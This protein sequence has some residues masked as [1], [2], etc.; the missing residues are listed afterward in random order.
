MGHR[1]HTLRRRLTCPCAQARSPRPERVVT[2][3]CDAGYDR[4][5]LRVQRCGAAARGLPGR[6]PAADPAPAE[7]ITRRRGCRDVSE[8]GTPSPIDSRQPEVRRNPWRCIEG[9]SCEAG[10]SRRAALRLS[11]RGARVAGGRCRPAP[12]GDA[13][14]DRRRRDLVVDSSLP[15]ATLRRPRKSGVAFQGRSWVMVVDLAA[16]D[17]CGKCSAGVRQEPLHSR[18][19]RVPPDLQDAGRAGNRAVL[20]SASLLPLRQPA[21]CARSVR[22]ARRS[23]GDDGIVLIDNERC[24]GCRFCMAACPFSV[25][26]VQ[27]EP[28]RQPAG[29]GGSR[30]LARVGLPATRRHRREVRLLRRHGERRDSYRTASARVRWSAIYFG[31]ENEDAVTNSKG[32]TCGSRNCS[33]TGP[34]SATW[35]SSARSR[36]CYYLPPTTGAIRRRA[37][38]ARNPAFRREERRSDER[39]A[40][41]HPD[42]TRGGDA[43][44]PDASSVER[45][46]L[47]TLEPLGSAGRLWIAAL[48]AVCAAA[49]IAWIY[50]LVTASASP[51]CVTTCRGAPT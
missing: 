38:P 28:A 27:L 5:I 39:H 44:R 47:A 19:S 45:D 36:A 24:I 50:Q 26:L 32:D 33:A 37:S 29:S 14:I 35:R 8:V 30:L 49:L 11:E 41:G 48:L 21:L 3:C 10:S 15:R 16:C 43:K 25:A 6:L 20:V 40:N 2:H 12:A 17:G 9:N 22:W 7:G 46:L 31:D 1:C 34:A 42:P 4:R 18:R 13:G 51:T 23:S